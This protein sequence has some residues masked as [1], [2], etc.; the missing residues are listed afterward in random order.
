[1]RKSAILGLGAALAAAMALSA[2]GRDEA[3]APARD[4]ASLG[5]SASAATHERNSGRTTERARTPA[6]MMDGKPMWADNRQHSAQ[7]N[8]DYQ[9]DHWGSGFGAKD[10]RDYAKKAL[11]F[12][13][14]P[15]AGVQKVTRSNGDVLLYDKS[16]NT[17]AIVR[18]DGA[19]RLFRKPPGGEADWEK[20]KSEA[21]SGGSGY[22]GGSRYHAPSASDYSRGQDN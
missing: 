1:M 3:S 18:R 21:S 4:H 10:S 14:H 17:F 7:E 15:P 5:D 9:F 6:P 13:G 12:T 16:S 2:C 19:P 20:A 11:A 8:L 22:R